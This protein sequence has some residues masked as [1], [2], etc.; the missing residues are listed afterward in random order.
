M[1]LMEH[2]YELR[3]RLFFAVLGLFLGTVVGFIWYTVKIPALGIPSLGDIMIHPYCAVPAEYRNVTGDGTSCQLVAITPFSFLQVRLKAALL[4]GSIIS[5]PIWLYQLW[6][7]VTP[8]LYSKERKF[9]VSFVSMGG[10]L[11]FAGSALAY[12]VIGEGL[13]VLLSFAGE[14]G[15]AQLTPDSYFSFLIAMLII[16]GLSFEVP[17][18]LVMLNFAGVLKG[19]KLAQARRYAFFGMVVLAGL[20]VPGNDPITMLALAISLCILYEL[21]VQVSKFHDKRKAK[22]LA[23]EGFGELSDDEAS[24][25][26]IAAGAPEASS[27]ASVTGASPTPTAT[28]LRAD[29]RLDDGDAT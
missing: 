27:A 23:V 22:R 2:L 9:A 14:D 6:A 8:A 4:V 16:F 15:V 7:F 11:F 24:P 5:S 3:R 26:P 12:V 18:L 28:P 29:H 21:A 19:A 1:S 17:L 20:V 13:K 25:S 10:F